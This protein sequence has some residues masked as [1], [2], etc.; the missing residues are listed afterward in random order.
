[1][2]KTYLPGI[3][4]YTSFNFFFLNLGKMMTI[5]LLS[6]LPPKLVMELNLF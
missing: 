1:M 2:P 4:A 5:P 6:S 3:Q